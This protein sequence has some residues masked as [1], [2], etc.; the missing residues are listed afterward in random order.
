MNTPKKKKIFLTLEQR[1][2]AIKLLESGKSAKA[3][4]DQYG[5]GR[6]QIQVCYCLPL[7]PLKSQMFG[8]L[9]IEMMFSIANYILN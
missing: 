2:A 3:V 5:C 8:Y 9:K 4:A 6:T 7:G 1:V